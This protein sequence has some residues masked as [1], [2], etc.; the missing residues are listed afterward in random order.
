MLLAFVS[1]EKL[2]FTGLTFCLSRR[3]YVYG[4]A[5]RKAGVMCLTVLCWKCDLLLLHNL[6]VGL[7]N[8]LWLSDV[9]LQ[10][11]TWSILVQIMMIFFYTGRLFSVSASVGISSPTFVTFGN[12]V[13][14]DLKS[15]TK[16]DLIRQLFQV[17]CTPFPVLFLLGDFVNVNSVVEYLPRFFFTDCPKSVGWEKNER[18]KMGPRM[19]NLSSS[20]DPTK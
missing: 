10:H 5:A 15:N 8:L 19:V 6:Q 12:L 14:I 1:T 17:P 16:W 4:I 20:M 13:M 3:L 2:Y 9:I 18:Q 11:G 7:F